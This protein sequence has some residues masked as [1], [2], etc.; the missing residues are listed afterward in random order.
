MVNRK[1]RKDR[2]KREW[3]R[4]VYD[5]IKFKNKRLVRTNSNENYNGQCSAGTSDFGVIKNGRKANN[6]R[7][8]WG[9]SI[10]D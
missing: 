9:V 2:P 1:S 7:G 8:K 5:G 6:M 3:L 10:S 4:V